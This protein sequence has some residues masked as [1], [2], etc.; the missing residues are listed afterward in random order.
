MGTSL[1]N[2]G[3]IAIAILLAGFYALL[4]FGMLVRWGIGDTPEAVRQQRFM[5][6][7]AATVAVGLGLHLRWRLPGQVVMMASAIPPA[8]LYL[9]TIVAP[10]LAVLMVYLWLRSRRVQA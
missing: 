1:A 4:G 6:A 9:W 3:F 8:M 10:L 5:L 7:F 2:K